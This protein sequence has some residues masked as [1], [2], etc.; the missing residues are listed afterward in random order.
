MKDLIVS[1]FGGSSVADA[2]SMKKVAS[3]LNDDH[4]RRLVVLSATKGTTN[5]LLAFYLEKDQGLLRE[6]RIRH[7]NI[8]RELELDNDI[9]KKMDIL[10]EDA[11][12]AKSIV[13][14][15]Q[16]EAAI[17]SLG[18][19]LSTLLFHE[20]IKK[21]FFSNALLVDARDIIVTDSH[22]RSAVPDTMATKNQAEINLSKKIE[23]Q[24]LV[25][26]QGFIGRDT[27]GRTTLLGRGGSD[28]SAALFAEAVNADKLEIWTDVPGVAT[29]DPRIVPSATI[30]E[31]LTYEE[32]SELAHMG[33][34]ILH[35]VTMAPA[36]RAKIDVFVGSTFA[37]EKGG[38][39][40]RGETRKKSSIRSIAYKED[41]TMITLSSLV[42]HHGRGFLE[43]VTGLF[44][45]HRINI[46]HVTTSETS[47]SIIIQGKYTLDE[48]LI[49]D[50]SMENKVNVEH[51][52]SQ[53]SFVGE[54]L[55]TRSDLLAKIV[56]TLSVFNLRAILMGAGRHNI[57]FLLKRDA[58]ILALTQAHRQFLEGGHPWM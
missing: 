26:T 29:T 34:R 58:A 31:E 48:S 19:Q 51:G 25:V 39:W 27:K 44:A 20:Y 15:E 23:Q 22:F 38:T 43:K 28:Y 46:E 30:I 50:L 21:H 4:R 2:A 1:K 7:E 42:M 5:Q 3:I 10:F 9:I 16:R 13:D 18:E 47:T 14:E 11:L 8:A 37:P 12:A 57:T 6:V 52:L 53:I 41:Q 33:A 32:A 49:R 36:M 54:D 56:E 24:Q 17:L 45:Y 35:P 55:C 40:I